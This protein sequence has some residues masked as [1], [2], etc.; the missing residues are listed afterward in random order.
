MQTLIHS[1]MTKRSLVLVAAVSIL[2]IGLFV[3]GSSDVVPSTEPV[4]ATCDCGTDC[5]C[6][7]DGGTCGEDCGCKKDGGTCNC[8]S[9]W[10]TCGCDKGCKWCDG[11]CGM[12]TQQAT[13]EVAPT[14]LPW[15]C[16]GGCKGSCGAK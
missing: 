2:G 3:S 7:K 10:S 4:V 6:K 14:K 5:D 11:S 15:S 8:Q 12:K 1:E 9:E 16:S 13:D